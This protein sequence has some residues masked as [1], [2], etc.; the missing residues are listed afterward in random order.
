MKR[1][2]LA[3][4]AVLP[5][6]L[7][8]VGLGWCDPGDE[9]YAALLRDHVR[10]GLVDYPG[11]LAEKAKLGQYLDILACVEPEALPPAEQEAYLINAYNAWTLWLIVTH[12]PVATIKDIGGLFSSPWKI[13][14]VALPGRTVSLDHLEHELLLPRFKDPRLHMALNCSAKSCPPLAAV[15]Y[16]A[17]ELDAQL[18]RA[19]R[20]FV[21]D[22]KSN[23]FKDGVLYLS[24]IFDW[25]GP[26]FGGEKGAVAF[27]LRYAAPDMASA[28]RAAGAGLKVKY[29]DYD[30]SLNRAGN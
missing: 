27:A 6:C 7:F 28:I 19:A 4:L 16:L 8:S 23:R 11:L 14:L 17:G 5:V 18:D 22:P 12:Y 2:C 10:G 21:N 9:M 26:D 1:T 13:A 25:Y 15:P 24:R 29:L 3:A 20:E 30:W